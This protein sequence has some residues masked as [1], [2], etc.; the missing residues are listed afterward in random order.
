M[1]G[2]DAQFARN[3][4]AFAHHL[5]S[6]QV[7]V[8]NQCLGRC[9][10]IRAARPDGHDA[11][12]RLQ[13][14]AIAR[15]DERSRVISHSQHGLQATQYTVGTQSRVSSIAERTKLPWCFSSLASNRSNSVNASAVAPAKPANT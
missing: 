14:V 11:V 13:H 9:L 10:G 4:Q 7:G 8:V 15:N 1:I 5:L 2:V 6:T 12:L 3:G